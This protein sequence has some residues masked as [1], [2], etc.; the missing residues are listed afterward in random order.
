MCVCVRACVRVC[1][2]VCILFILPRLTRQGN[3][4]ADE[5]VHHLVPGLGNGGSLSEKTGA[6]HWR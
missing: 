4:Q 6:V 3:A 5:M 2:C 1:A